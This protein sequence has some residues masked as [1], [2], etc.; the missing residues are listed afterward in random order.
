MFDFC[1]YRQS[2]SQSASGDASTAAQPVPRGPWGTAS[3]LPGEHTVELL[4]KPQLPWPQ[5]LA[6]GRVGRWGCGLLPLRPLVFL[7]HLDSSKA[8]YLL[9]ADHS[10][11]LPECVL[12]P[13]PYLG[14]HMS[15]GFPRDNVWSL[16]PFLVL[17]QI[18][19]YDELQMLQSRLPVVSG[20][21][22]WDGFRLFHRSFLLW[23]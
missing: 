5:G 13:Q 3:C 22:R 2:T 11:L 16:T 10:V 14:S 23:L 20:I 6:P 21:W 8:G 17:S 12:F 4:A 19:G 1:F 7:H 15:L 18:Y 9:T